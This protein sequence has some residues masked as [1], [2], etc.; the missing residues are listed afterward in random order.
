MVQQVKYS[1]LSFL[2]LGLLMAQVQ[3]LDQE[4][5]QAMGM[6]KKKVHRKVD[7]SAEEAA[8]K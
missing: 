7:N 5:S 1:V 4:L 6:A 8:V 3:S 2:Q